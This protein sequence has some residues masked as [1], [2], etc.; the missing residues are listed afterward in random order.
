MAEK[1]V[2]NDTTTGTKNDIEQATEL[3]RRMVCEWGMSPDL[4]PVAY[5]QEEEPIFL[6]KEIARHKDYSEETARKIDAAVT[7]IIREAQRN[8]EEILTTHLDQLLLLA[9][10][11]VEKETLDDGEIRELLGFPPR[12][13]GLASEVPEEEG[14]GEG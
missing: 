10:T 6:G 3:A 7:G 5:G 14:R 8:V 9:D 2:Y 1:I 11:L 13:E 4:G 12:G